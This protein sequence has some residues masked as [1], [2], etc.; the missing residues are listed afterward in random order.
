MGSVVIAASHASHPCFRKFIA[1]D[2]TRDLG[3]R[4]AGRY[5]SDSHK[6][7]AFCLGA[8]IMRAT[9][10]Y[11]ILLTICALLTSG[12][13]SLLYELQPH[14]LRMLNRGPAPSLDPEFSALPREESEPLIFRAQN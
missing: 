11:W 4:I 14:R 2:S 7:R 8:G 3:Q 1:A 10:N 6:Y 9:R 13:A 12:C 5:K